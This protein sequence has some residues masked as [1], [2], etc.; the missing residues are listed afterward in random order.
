[1]ANH[2]TLILGG[3][4]SRKSSFAQQQAAGS[5]EPVLFV[6]TATAGDADMAARIAAHQASRPKEWQTLEAPQNVGAAIRQ[7][8]PTG[9]V[10]LDCITLLASN[11]LLSLPENVAQEEYQ[12]ALDHEIEDLISTC[13]QGS[14]EWLVVSNEV[15]LGVVPPYS[16]GRM[17]R[18]GIGR[19]NQRLAQAA[20]DV[21]FLVAGLPMKVK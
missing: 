14:A 3:A 12:A 16:L 6:A 13:R 8:H 15:G 4:R 11:V 17:Y 5:G 18:D 21:F 20:D 2:L 10:L 7:H 9:I 1:M 19:A